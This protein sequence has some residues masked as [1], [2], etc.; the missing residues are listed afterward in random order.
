[1]EN[2][3][4]GPP[5]EA[6]I[7]TERKM[8]IICIGAG[9]SG[10]CF[11]YKLQRSFTNVSLTI[12]E[13]NAEVSGT[14]FENTYPG[15]RCD[16][17]GI[18]YTYTFEPR[19]DFSGVYPAAAETRQYFQDFKTRHG[20]GRY[21]RMRHRVVGARWRDDGMRW[22][23][24]VEDLAGGEVMTDSCDILVN[25]CGYLN[26]WHWPEIPGLA[27]FKG[28]LLHSANWDKEVD[29][30]GKC[31]GLIG[32]GYVGC[33]CNSM[34]G[35]LM[36]RISSSSAIQ[37]LPSIQRIAKRITTVIRTP[38]W[39]SPPFGPDQESFGKDEGQDSTVESGDLLSLRK[40]IEDGINGFF[41]FAFADSP[42]QAAMRTAVT[43]QMKQR[44][45]AAHLED[46]LIPCYGV[47]ARR[48]TPGRGYLEALGAPN[49]EIL[50]GGCE[51]VT[52]SGIVVNGTEVPVDVLICATGF[53]TSYKPQFP[54]IG[55]QGKNLQD[56]WASEAKAYMSIA[57]AGFPNYMMFTGPNSPVANGSLLPAIG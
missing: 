29:L 10:L 42:P 57:V 39:I 53:D 27:G 30:V 38:T 14:W 56:E 1:M 13:K 40:S 23:V 21:C 12:Y 5:Q 2:G 36:T 51:S 47:G 15:C 24:Q 11:A 7:Y 32:N 35:F 44:L 45:N 22:E 31:V 37:I 25:A 33:P 4:G 50:F 55:L 19:G 28:S 41:R 48:L 43:A 8:R 3:D 26:A 9:P 16:F 18:N 6:A 34:G 46:R 49:V 17:P 52:E 20:L 54:I